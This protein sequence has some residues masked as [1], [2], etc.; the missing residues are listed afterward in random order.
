MTSK[1]LRLMTLATSL[2]D[3]FVE[4]YREREQAGK[5]PLERSFNGLGYV[6]FKRTYARRVEGEDRTEEWY[7]TVRR[8]VEGAIKVVGDYTVEESERLFDHIWNLRAFPSGRSLWQLGTGNQHRL[9]GDSL[10]NCWFV[11]VR[12]IEDFVWMF[13]RLMLGGGVGFDVRHG[14]DLGIVRGGTVRH[15][16]RADADFITPDSR[17]GWSLLLKT[18][19][20]T[21]I[22]GGNLTYST[23]LIRPEGAPIEGFGGIA[24]GPGILVEGI[25]KICEIINQARGRLLTSVDVLDI[26]N[27]IGGIVVSG[28]VR[29]SAQIAIGSPDDGSFLRSKNWALGIP[30]HRAMS[31]NSVYLRSWEDLDDAFWSGY[32]GEGEPFGIVN[33]ERAQTDGR[34]GERNPD[35][36]IRGFNP[37]GE[38]P[39]ANRESCNL[40]EL[41][42]PRFENYKQLEDAALLLYRLQKHIA[43][44]E[45]L[46]GTSNTITHRNMRLGLSITGVFQS[47]RRQLGWLDPLYRELK[48][49]DE[50]YSALNGF[51]SSVRLTT[52]QPSG[53]KSLLA[54][55][56]PGAHPGFARFHVRRVRMAFNDPTFEYVRQRGYPWEFVRD[57]EGNEQHRTV[58]VEFPCEFPF[59]TPSAEGV[60]WKDMLKMQEFLQTVWAD[61]AVSIT[62]YYMG[63]DLP[64]IQAYMEQNWTKFKSVSFLPRSDHGF[65]QAPLE[66]ISIPEYERRLA[67]LNMEARIEIKGDALPILDSDCEGGSCPIR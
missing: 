19:L 36:S 13:N 24:S 45:Y 43:A 21:V 1:A 27:L 39:L 46:D 3:E 52:V 58:V 47:T 53:T 14:A 10:V 42:V 37:C 38:I 31:N 56:T 17:E 4:R 48:D 12:S 2:S 60:G 62:V 9:G 28:N 63:E 16:D 49:Y 57:F 33:V 66:A 34:L 35:E 51:P 18:V 50:S 54:G 67:D 59:G 41:V 32:R 6:V 44:L 11:E 61:N 55:V 25:E 5:N 30:N 64:D 26:S 23:Q 20:E 15:E 7:E 8:V 65:D 29:R 22:N 40:A